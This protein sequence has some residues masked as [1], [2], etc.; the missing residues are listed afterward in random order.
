[1]VGVNQTKE[2][3]IFG[4]AI[5][6][7]IYSSLADDGKITLS[8]FPKFSESLF[9][10]PAALEGIIEVPAELK[11]LDES[12]L[13]ELKELVLSKLPNIGEKWLVVAKE[14]LNIGLSALKVY[15]AFKS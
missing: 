6:N 4:L 14:S 11:D 8:D 5:G 1:M 2:L 10:V 13:G 15:N 9:T 7:G 3:L 12:E